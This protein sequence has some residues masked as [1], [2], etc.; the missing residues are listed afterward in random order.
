[1]A[2]LNFNKVV[3]AAMKMPVVTVEREPF[4]RKELA[5]YCDKETIQAVIEHGTRGLVDKRIIDKI[6]TGCINYQTTVVCSTSA[7]AGLP[8]GWALVG[9]IP[10]D[11]VQFYANAISLAEKMM[12]LY[13]WPDIADENGQVT[14]ATANIMIMWIGVMMGAQGAELGVRTLLNA[15]GKELEKS[16]LKMAVE[17]SWFYTMSRQICKWIGVKLTEEGFAKSASKIVPL[18]GAPISAG[19]TYFTFKP[20]CKRLKKEMDYEWDSMIA[21]SQKGNNRLLPA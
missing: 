19:I 12:Y 3:K 9:T 18:V 21:L 10:V 6:A 1:M 15:L 7:L 2:V 16:L 5:P 17:K 11:V 8:G 13:G 4:L 20:M 14:D